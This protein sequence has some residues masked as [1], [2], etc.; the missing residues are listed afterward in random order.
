MRL[1]KVTMMTVVVVCLL[2]VNG[3]AYSLPGGMTGYNSM[4][5]SF[6]WETWTDIEPEPTA[7][8]DADFL[9]FDGNQNVTGFKPV[10]GFGGNLSFLAGGSSNPLSSFQ[11]TVGYSNYSPSASAGVASFGLEFSW[12]AGQDSYGDDMYSGIGVYR[13]TVA[14]GA[15]SGVTQDLDG[16]AVSFWSDDEDNYPEQLEF[17][18][19][20][21]GPN[22]SLSLSLSGGQLEAKFLL[23]D[24]TWESFALIDLTAL[25]W[26]STAMD[27]V[28]GLSGQEADV[29]FANFQSSP[30]APAATPIPGAVWLLGSGLV[31]LAGFRKRFRR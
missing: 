22:G 23:G 5:K 14:A 2:A 13:G 29:D 24:G 7:P 1:M 10:P 30:E 16:F 26:S 17:S 9:K 12:H 4:G 3:F 11:A 15:E 28:L 21:G 8:A 20:P 6:V 31:G 25:G 19:T 18:P 27:Q